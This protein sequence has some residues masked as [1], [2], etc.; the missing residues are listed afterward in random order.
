M[1]QRLKAHLGAF[2]L[3]LFCITV[4]GQDRNNNSV[5]PGW[6]IGDEGTHLSFS[7][8]LPV[9]MGAMPLTDS[10]CSAAISDTSGN[11]LFATASGIVYDRFGAVMDQGNL[12][13]GL[14]GDVTQGSLIFPRPG[15]LTSMTSCT[16]AT[17]QIQR[18]SFKPLG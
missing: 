1:R 15:M 8:G 3:P 10:E 18:R 14:N 4:R 5:V 17:H 7:T 13:M 9:D 12:F 6:L 11:F 16:S 2:L